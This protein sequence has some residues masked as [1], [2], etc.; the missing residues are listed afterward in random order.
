VAKFSAV[1]RVLFA[2]TSTPVD[3]MALDPQDGSVVVANNVGIYRLSADLTT[4]LA[5]LTFDR[6]LE[7]S[8]IVVGPQETVPR[9]SFVDI[10]CVE[11]DLWVDFRG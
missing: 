4:L 11:R 2:S 10:S 6:R 1:L 9:K 8:A 3:L 7:V 5:S